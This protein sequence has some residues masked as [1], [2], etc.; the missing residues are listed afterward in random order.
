MGAIEPTVET[1]RNW[2]KVHPSENRIKTYFEEVK[3]GKRL[4]DALLPK[5]IEESKELGVWGIYNVL[6]II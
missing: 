3:A 2:L 1:W 5:A 4:T 6:M